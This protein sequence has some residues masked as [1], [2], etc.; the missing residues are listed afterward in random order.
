MTVTSVLALA[1]LGGTTDI[2]SFLFFV[3]P[4]KVRGG[5]GFLI[6]NTQ[7]TSPSPRVG[8]GPKPDFF[9]YVV[10]PEPEPELSLTYLVNFSSLKKPEPKV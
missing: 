2:G 1:T 9:I 3:V 7:S 4:P 8:L 10:K 6:D 5:S